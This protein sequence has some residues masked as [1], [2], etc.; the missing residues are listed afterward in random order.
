M[1]LA[2]VGVVAVAVSAVALHGCGDDDH[3]HPRETCCPVCGDGICSGDENGCNCG[4]D[5][6]GAVCPAILSECG[7][8][9]CERQASP[10]ESFERCPQDC[11]LECPRCERSDHHVFLGQ[12]RIAGETCPHDAAEAYRN[13]N[14]V[15]CHRCDTDLDCAAVGSVEDQCQFRCGPGCENDTGSCCGV[16]ECVAPLR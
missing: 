14:L 3:G 15:V 11:P 10:G 16:R 4:A 7:N 13:D 1:T 12:R 5:C 2:V 6:S 9:T 8:G